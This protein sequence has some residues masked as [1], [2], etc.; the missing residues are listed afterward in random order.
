MT[1]CKSI[2]IFMKLNIL[3]VMMSFDD[4]YKANN[5]IIY[6]YSSIIELLMYA[7]IIIQ[8]DLIYSFSILSRYCFNLKS[9]HI[10]A[11]IRVFKYIK[12]TF[13]YDIY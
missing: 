12:K 8:L 4:D 13:N 6:W 10:K 7:M 3:N 1:D 2:N 5:N 11:I 9:T